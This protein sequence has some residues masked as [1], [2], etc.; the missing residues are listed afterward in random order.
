MSQSVSI[1]LTSFPGAVHECMLSMQ[2]AVQLACM[3]KMRRW[4]LKS[5]L[6]NK[7]IL[8]RF[9]FILRKWSPIS[10]RAERL[11]MLDILSAPLLEIAMHTTSSDYIDM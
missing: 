3:G 9:I 4:I 11:C 1:K 10:I 5:K 8:A 2:A 6:L 7:F